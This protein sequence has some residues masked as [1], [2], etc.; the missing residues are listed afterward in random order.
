MAEQK[1]NRYNTQQNMVTAQP[2]RQLPTVRRMTAEESA[3]LATVM[4]SQAQPTSIQIPS[5]PQA[6]HSAHMKEN[7]DI[8][9]T[10]KVA[11]RF[12]IWDMGIFGAVTASIAGLIWYQVGGDLTVY[13]LGWLVVWG[14]VSYFAMN[15]NR[16]QAYDHSPTGVA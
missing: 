7:Y 15:R 5:L 9:N 11:E 2:E 10:A 3:A 6:T 13:S 14:A 1:T 4:P 12:I 16:A 8:R